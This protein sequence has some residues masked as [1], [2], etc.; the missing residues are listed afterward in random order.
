[1]AFLLKYIHPLFRMELR[2]NS[3]RKSYF[4]LWTFLHIHFQ[5]IICTH[6]HVDSVDKA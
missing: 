2:R 3:S 6:F 1:M 4:L 5:N